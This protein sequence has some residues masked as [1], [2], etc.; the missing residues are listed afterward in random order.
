MIDGAPVYLLLNGKVL[1]QEHTLEEPFKY[2]TVMIARSGSFI[3]VPELNMGKSSKTLV[4]PVVF[5]H[6]AH[7]LRMCR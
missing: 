3:G 2:Q 5:S 7:L 6:S 4:F 1:L